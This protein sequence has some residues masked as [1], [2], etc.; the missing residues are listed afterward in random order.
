MSAPEFDASTRQCLAAWERIAEHPFFADCYDTDG[1]LLD[2]M[3]T[4]LDRIVAEG[5]E[6]PVSTVAERVA[7]EHVSQFFDCSCGHN[8]TPPREGAGLVTHA[9]IFGRH[10]AEVTEAAV[11]AQIAAD[12]GGPFNGTEGLDSFTLA[13]AIGRIEKGG[14]S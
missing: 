5:G 4:K 7:A 10:I 6:P 9:D 1:T 2:A 13:W 14:A 11:R 8:I 12:I 3:L